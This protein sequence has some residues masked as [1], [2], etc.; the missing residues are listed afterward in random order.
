HANKVSSIAAGSIT[1]RR[2]HLQGTAARRSTG[3]AG[4]PL[5]GDEQK[6]EKQANHGP[7]PLRRG[8]RAEGTVVDRRHRAGRLTAGLRRALRTAPAPAS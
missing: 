6:N 4:R 2:R 3:T 8:F 1:A 7:D 5:L